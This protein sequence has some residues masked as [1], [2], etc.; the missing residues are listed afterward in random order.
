[1]AAHLRGRRREAVDLFLP[2]RRAR[3]ASRGRRRR[4]RAA[5]AH[6]SRMPL[7]E[8]AARARDPGFVDEIFADPA[9]AGGS[10]PARGTDLFPPSTSHASGRR[11]RRAVARESRRAG[12]PPTPGDPVDAGPA[13]SANRL[14][15]R[16]I[17]GAIAPNGGAGR[18]R[19]PTTAGGRRA[20]PLW[21]RP[22]PGAAA[23]GPVRGD[24][25][26]PK[27]AGV[28]VAGRGPPAALRAR[29]L[30]RPSGAGPVRPLP[31]RRPLSGRPAARALLRL[32]K[33]ASSASPRGAPGLCGGR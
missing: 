3:A 23:Q 15:A 12:R 29:P 25:A 1:M 21:R 26:R 8:A 27:R 4:L 13:Q 16:A 24:P 32:P 31:R 19:R 28:P 18:R 17:A 6:P 11:L 33:R 30:R 5:P 14:L 2:G 20:L 10:T 7:L 9:S 22:H